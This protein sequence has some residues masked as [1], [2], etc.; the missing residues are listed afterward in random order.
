MSSGRAAGAEAPIGSASEVM[1]REEEQPEGSE[2][3]GTTVRAPGAS[4]EP[5]SGLEGNVRSPVTDVCRAL[6]IATH[7]QRHTAVWQARP[8]APFRA[9]WQR[10]FPAPTN[11]VCGPS[12]Q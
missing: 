3:D 10:C 6:A 9:L 11:H 7:W 8:T 1:N 2:Q 12:V 5:S 4:R